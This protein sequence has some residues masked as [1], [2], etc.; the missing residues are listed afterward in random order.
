MP[1]AGISVP[2]PPQ[3]RQV[4]YIKSIRTTN[5]L[6]SCLASHEYAWEETRGRAGL[7]IKSPLNDDLVWDTA[8]TKFATT[9]LHIDDQGFGTAITV[10]SG[11]KYWVLGRRN[12]AYECSII[13]RQGDIGCIDAF[14]GRWDPA[15]VV[16]DRFEYEGVYLTPGSIL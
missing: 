2:V 15:L 7:R 1:L 9:W 11:G 4:F 6:I 3:Y 16:D 5:N 14:T 13:S 10:A 8:A 12:Q